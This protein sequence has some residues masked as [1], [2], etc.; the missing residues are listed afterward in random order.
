MFF[1]LVTLA[2]A[3]S[4]DTWDRPTDLPCSTNSSVQFP[5]D[6]VMLLMIGNE[7]VDMCVM[8]SDMANPPFCM[9]N[10]VLRNISIFNRRWAASV[11]RQYFGF[12][13]RSTISRPQP[14]WRRFLPHPIR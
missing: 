8:G 9:F 1:K 7:R 4:A 6:A 13:L 3:V 14:E 10:A 11:Q 2:V 5:N 12:F